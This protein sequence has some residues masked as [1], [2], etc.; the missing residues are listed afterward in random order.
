MGS[1][2]QPQD[3]I[4]GLWLQSLHPPSKQCLPLLSLPGTGPET[5]TLLFNSSQW[6]EPSPCGDGSRP[7]I[8]TISLPAR[9][10]SRVAYVFWS[11]FGLWTS[12][13]FL[14]ESLA[15]IFL[16]WRQKVRNSGDDYFFFAVPQT[17]V[18]WEG[19]G[20]NLR[21]RAT[22]VQASDPPSNS[23]V[24]QDL[25][26]MC[27]S[28]HKTKTGFSVLSV[29]FIPFCFHLS[30]LWLRLC[31]LFKLAEEEFCCCGEDDQTPSSELSPGFV[32]L[33]DYQ[34]P[35]SEVLSQKCTWCVPFVSSFRTFGFSS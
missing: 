13:S 28:T 27:H 24:T 20:D 7:L 14:E 4:V 2:R 9:L 25:T 10:D 32:L 3:L 22:E 29:C 23:V 30:I 11:P 17:A 33:S 16:S 5:R 6:A 31:W 21:S 18:A 26:A 34:E 35:S 8:L 1:R 12:P 15:G 19:K